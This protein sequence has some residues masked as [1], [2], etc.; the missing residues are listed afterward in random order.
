MGPAFHLLKSGA[1][2]HIF[3]HS[4]RK[5]VSFK[6][7]NNKCSHLHT[8]TSPFLSAYDSPHLSAFYNQLAGGGCLGGGEG[9]KI[10]ACGQTTCVDGDGLSCER[11]A[12]Y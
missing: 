8:K 1:K 3:F 10:G 9:E 12:E 11:R 6:S 7:K 5:K 4:Q 2:I